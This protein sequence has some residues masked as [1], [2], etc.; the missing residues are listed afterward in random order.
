MYIAFSESSDVFTT[1]DKTGRILV[2]NYE[3]RFIRPD[4]TFQPR[5]RFK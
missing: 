5:S 4:G 1:L 3:T 2:W